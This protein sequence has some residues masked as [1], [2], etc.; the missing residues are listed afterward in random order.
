[1]SANPPADSAG[2]PDYTQG[3]QYQVTLTGAQ[4]GAGVHNFTVT[5]TDGTLAAA[6]PGIVNGPVML[7]PYFQGFRVVPLSTPNQSTGITTAAVGDQVLVVGNLKFPYNLTTGTPGQINNIVITITKPDGTKPALSAAINSVTLE[8][9]GS[10]NPVDWTGALAV[11]YPSSVDP[12]LITG[13]SLTLNASGIWQV[14]GSWTGNSTWDSASTGS[15]QNAQILVGGP[16]RTV[17]VT[18]GYRPYQC[19]GSGHD[20]TAHGDQFL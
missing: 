10:G 14:T 6:S 1:M 5:A 19:A 7:V 8:R 12:A 2:N 16:M 18:N 20:H 11:T 13:D 9:D 3:V 15:S 17:A 4:L